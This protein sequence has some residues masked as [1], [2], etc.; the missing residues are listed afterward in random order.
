MVGQVP[1]EFSGF[2]IKALLAQECVRYGVTLR[3]STMT[4]LSAG[5]GGFATQGFGKGDSAG[6]HY[7]TNFYR[8]INDVPQNDHIGKELWQSFRRGLKR[9]PFNSGGKKNVLMVALIMCSS[10]RQSSTTCDTLT[11]HVMFLQS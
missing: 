10:S 8:A 2:D 6:Y 5:K 9:E 1:G 7:S 4:H 11:T 3:P